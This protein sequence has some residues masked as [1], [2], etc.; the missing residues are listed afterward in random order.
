MDFIQSEGVVLVVIPLMVKVFFDLLPEVGLQIS[1]VI[2]PL[3]GLEELMQVV[4]FIEIEVEF[5]DL[6][7]QNM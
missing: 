2:I 4:L 1:V 5:F 7:E 3:K 6:K